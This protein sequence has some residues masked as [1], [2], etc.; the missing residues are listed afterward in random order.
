[1]NFETNMILQRLVLPGVCSLIGCILIART[2][3]GEDWF[4]DKPVPGVWLQNLC[5]AFLCGVGFVASDFCSRAILCKPE[6]WLNW[7]ASYQWNWM[8]WLIPAAMMTLA[9]ARSIFSTPIQ[10]VSIA[11]TLLWGMSIGI[12]FVSLNEGQVWKDQATKQMPWLAAGITAIALNTFSLNAMAKSGA[13]RWHSLIV[14]AQLGCVAAI[15][16]LTYGSLGEFGLAGSAVAAAASVVSLV[17]PSTSKTHYGWQLSTVVL[18]LVIL[19]VCILCVSRFF[20]PFSLPAWLL[21]SVLFLPALAG[22]ADLV[23]GRLSNV[24]IRPLIAG[25]VCSGVLGW[26]LYLALS[27]TPDW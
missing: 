6:E 9:I 2:D 1:M 16:M 3:K 7:K 20:E 26:I 18:P 11:A 4:E 22:L 12:L 17:K 10:Y 15:A 25:A 5:G 27:K 19:A 21:A 13:S 24:W 14:L 23:F 8:I